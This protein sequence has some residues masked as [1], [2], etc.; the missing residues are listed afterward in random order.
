MATNPLS[1][2][3]LCNTGVVE[4]I[5]GGDYLLH[6]C[7]CGHYVINLNDKTRELAHATS[8]LTDKLSA[9]IKEQDLKGLAPYF[10]QWQDSGFYQLIDNT[11]PV[12]VPTL[13]NHHWPRDVPEVIDRA[14]ANLA[15][16]S[17]EAGQEL[18]IEP[19]DVRHFLSRSVSEARFIRDALKEYGYITEK[20]NSPVIT[21]T[22]EG[23]K[24]FS[25]LTKG[26]P[27]PEHPAFV[28]MWFSE[29]MVAVSEQ[30]IEP[31]V[32]EAGYKVTRSNLEAYDDYIMNKVLG[33][34]QVAPFLVADFTGNRN[35]VYFEAGF[36]RGLKIPV[37]HTCKAGDDFEKAHFD[38]KQ[39]NTVVWKE[40]SELRKKLVAQIRGI[41]GE[42]P[43]IKRPSTPTT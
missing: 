22:P 9:L 6:D 43:F 20:R 21:V 26:V 8:P 23:W 15:R 2:C 33:D 27:K 10:L 37:I 11:L 25:E 38:I 14:L 17:K 42:G 35:G 36:A 18:E 31:A 12:N 34:I 19:Y 16:M 41:V 32:I 13:L 1:R 7:D 30:A 29:E 4:R 28:A 5:Q 40:P 24:H 3:F 39:I